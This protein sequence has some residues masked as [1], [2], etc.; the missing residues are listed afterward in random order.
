MAAE[1]HLD[2]VGAA[3]YATVTSRSLNL[4][5][6]WV[7]CE[8]M[9]GDTRCRKGESHERLPGDTGHEEPK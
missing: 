1:R 2:P 6:H 3:K 8:Y 4:P 9:R 5:P 7:R